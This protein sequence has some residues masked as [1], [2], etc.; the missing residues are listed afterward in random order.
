MWTDEKPDTFDAGPAAI[1][2]PAPPP[3]HKCAVEK[4]ASWHKDGHTGELYR[5]PGTCWRCPECWMWWQAR[6]F[7]TG[8]YAAVAWEPVRP[9]TPAWFR[10]RK[11]AKEMR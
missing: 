10:C 8:K 3:R 9:L 11:A 2:V 7:G 5:P 6:R 1:E 4:S